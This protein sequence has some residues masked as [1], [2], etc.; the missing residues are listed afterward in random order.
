MN[1]TIS[2]NI[3]LCTGCGACVV[4][5][6]DQND[7]FPE[8]DQ[9]PFRRIYRIEN[10]EFPESVIKY[11]SIGCMHCE[12]APCV[13]GCPIGAIARDEKTGAIIINSE[14]CIGCHSCTISCPFG[15]P[16]FNKEG[17]MEKCNLCLERVEEGL[18]PAC[19][20]VCPTFALTFDSPNKVQEAKESKFVINFM[21]TVPKYWPKK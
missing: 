4:A 2:L 11:I 1:K 8:K 14:S 13:I 6:M 17:K 18:E 16:R 15:I 7:I 9:F 10:G 21:E 12:D 3:D 19:V 20:R 5:C